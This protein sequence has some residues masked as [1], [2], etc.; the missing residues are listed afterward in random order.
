MQ[1]K[2]E[3]ELFLTDQEK[4]DYINEESNLNDFNQKYNEES[5]CIYKIF[6]SKSYKKG[7]Q[8]FFNYGRCPN[9]IW[10]MLYGYGLVDNEYD[11]FTIHIQMEE[12]KK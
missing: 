2:I 11:G 12:G 10:I 9:R 8:L 1:D 3:N 7:D 5:D 6:T 4:I